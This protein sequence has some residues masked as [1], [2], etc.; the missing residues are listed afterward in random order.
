MICNEH[1][2]FS[3]K[4]ERREVRGEKGR[5][6]GERRERDGRKKEKEG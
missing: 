6:E 2:I 5:D 4:Q 3:S 1:F